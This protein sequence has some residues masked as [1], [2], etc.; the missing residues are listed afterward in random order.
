MMARVW[1]TMEYLRIVSNGF[2]VDG[3]ISP[4]K[5]KQTLCAVDR[6]KVVVKAAVYFSVTLILDFKYAKVHG[7]DKFVFSV[8]NVSGPK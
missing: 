3:L 4:V 2:T 6:T 1:E 7:T 5:T 8:G